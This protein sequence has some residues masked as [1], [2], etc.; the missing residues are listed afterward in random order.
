MLFYDIVLYMDYTRQ[1]L[2]KM[3]KFLA[4]NDLPQKA[5]LIFVFGGVTMPKVWQRTCDL[6]K[7][8]YAPKIY[9]AGGVGKKRTEQGGEVSEAEIIRSFL[10]E[11][12]V[13][14]ED[15]V[16]ETTSTNTLE[17]VVY[18]RDFITKNSIQSVIAVSK[19]F[20]MR[21][22]LATFAK[23]LPYLQV[24]CC[25]PHLNYEKMNHEEMDYV[26][27]RMCGETSRL[28]KYAKKGDIATIEIPQKISLVMKAEI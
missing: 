22:T 5:D 21:R 27:S 4:V 23:H 18:A 10:I 6:Y 26:F 12:G 2:E 20:H 25:P 19:P 17:N 11:K 7:S 16:I 15:I 28:Q 1:E 24:R 13:P 3:H 8:G 9:I 14:V